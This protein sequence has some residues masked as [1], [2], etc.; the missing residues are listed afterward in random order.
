MCVQLTAKTWRRGRRLAR[1]VPHRDQSGVLAVRSVEIARVLVRHAIA[2]ADRIRGISADVL[3]VALGDR[4]LAA[5]T[6]SDG[7]NLQLGA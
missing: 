7:R 3:F 5:P 6:G 4:I 2:A 1:A